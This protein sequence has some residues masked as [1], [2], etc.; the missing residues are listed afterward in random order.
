MAIG[1]S[2]QIKEIISLSRK[3]AIRLQ[4]SRVHVA[5]LVLGMLQHKGCLAF[6][7]FQHLDAS[8]V[9]LRTTL[10]SAIKRQ[11]TPMQLEMPPIDRIP[12]HEEVEGLLRLLLTSAQTLHLEAIGTGH[13]LLAILEHD[14]HTTSILRQFNITYQNVEAL[15]VYQP[16]HEHQEDYGLEEEDKDRTQQSVSSSTAQDTTTQ[17]AAPTKTP[18][19]DNFGSDLN[20]L[21]KEGKL[22]PIIGREKEIEDVVQILSRR[23]KN[24]ALLVGEPGVGKT[25]IAEGLALRIVQRR[26]TKV[27]QNKR[28]IA[29]DMAAL[30]AGTK[31]RGQFEE[32]MQ[33]MMNELKDSPHIILFI[34]ELHTIIGAGSATGTLDAANLLK[35]ALARGEFQCIGATTI[36]EYRQYLEKDGALARRFQLVN[37]VPTTTEETIAILNSIKD[38]Y[39]KHHAVKYDTETIQACV[40]LANR[41]INHRK[42][43][44]KAI[45]VMDEAGASVH[46]RHLKVPKSI[47]KLET[48]IAKVKQEKSKV[49]KDQRYET[50]AQL[51]DKERRLNEQLAQALGKWEAATIQQ[52]HAVT[53]EDVAAIVA[54]IAGI[55]LKRINH[56][57]DN[58]LLMLEKR[59]QRSIVGQDEAIERL[60]KTVQRTH[61]GFH[62]PE[63]PLGSFIFLG[64]TGVGKTA[65]AKALARELLGKEDAL[66]RIDMSEYME[67]FSTSRL[68]G[69]PPGYVG[70]EEGGQLTEKIRRNPY[71]IVLLDEIEKAHPEV[72]NLLLQM[73]DDGT[74]TDGLGR[75]VDC[76][77]TIV[78]MT[79]NVGAR[80]LQTPY[81]GFMNQAQ[82]KRQAATLKEKVHRALD[83]TF[84]P[85]FINRLD[86]VIVFNT[87]N[88]AQISQIV[89]IHLKQLHSRT[90]ALGYQL[91]FTKS[92]KDF[93]CERG[94]SPKYGVR[95]LQRAIQQYVEEA[96]TAKVLSRELQPGDI[97]R[98]NHRK[99]STGLDLRVKKIKAHVTLPVSTK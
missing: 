18:M 57:H 82:Q 49:V 92:A 34:D 33:T 63:K 80:E 70:Y 3:E 85:E 94:Y 7:I 17:R 30:V 11:A 44:D 53:V 68:V 26:V 77:N 4:S 74:L 46:L 32:R 91:E 97:V 15:V 38:S 65:L 16:N 10:E 78:I 40:E 2:Y 43:P 66:I 28:I 60:T 93:L 14:T 55:P 5:H 29:L 71:S 51:R 73:M 89:N 58:S 95:P 27:L 54:K 8:V 87:L 39:E 83:K 25:A 99:N 96:L 72:W 6:Q 21:A 19:L 47:V 23:K 64:P 84:N 45:D 48:A 13:L 75:C 42:L 22:D 67:K 9:A 69:A 37:I 86:A 79:S 12:L 31:Y 98:I 50:A 76:R 62:N 61:L 90:A 88:K 52:R 36:N 59:L 1:L 35:P 24:N 20:R 56:K 41:Y 81:M